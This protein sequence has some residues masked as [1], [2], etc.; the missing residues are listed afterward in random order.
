MNP[1]ATRLQREDGMA[2]VMSLLVLVFLTAVAM[3]VMVNTVSARRTG[4][5]SM[6]SQ[7]ALDIA[8]A[9]LAEAVS[10]LSH[11]DVQGTGDPH[12]VTQIFLADEAFLPL[13]GPDTTALATQQPRGEWLPY[14]AAGRGADVLTIHYKTDPATGAILRFDSNRTPSIQTQSGAPIYEVLSTGRVGD[15]RAKV[16]AEYVAS[17]LHPRLRAALTARSALTFEGEHVLVDGTNHPADA[18]WLA[19]DA[20]PNDAGTLPGQL[21]AAWS[22]ARVEFLAG[23]TARGAGTTAV[24][25]DQMAEFFEGPWEALGMT[26]REYT[27][28]AGPVT[29]ELP[30]MLNGVVRLDDNGSEGD[31]SGAWTIA[32]RQGEGMLVVDGDLTLEGDFQWQGL[33]Y[34]TGNLHVKGNASILGALVVGGRQDVVVKDAAFRVRYSSEAITRHVG[35]EGATFARLAWRQID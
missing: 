21:P 30:S 25:D 5:V 19:G 16:A 3:A 34:V 15:A 29:S 14:S 31:G 8:E 2:L 10:R 9:G 17:A 28:W 27:G 33:V 32:D 23:S 26:R 20:G 12:Q 18:R 13:T 35:R 1:T 4:A 24:R 7:Q 11:G 22:R 6:R